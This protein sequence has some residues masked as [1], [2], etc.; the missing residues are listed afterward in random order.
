[1]SDFEA[2][3]V[4]KGV[5]LASSCNELPDAPYTIELDD[6]LRITSQRWGTAGKS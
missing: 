1:M 2:I 5:L 6:T 3:P 4:R